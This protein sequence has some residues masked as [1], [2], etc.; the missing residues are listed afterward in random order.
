MFVWWLTFTSAT[1]A[2]CRRNFRELLNDLQTRLS[3]LQLTVLSA[4]LYQSN[5]ISLLFTNPI[6]HSHC[7]YE[8][9]IITLIL[10]NNNKQYILYFSFRSSNNDRLFLQILRMWN[11][12]VARQK[13]AC[14]DLWI[15]KIEA[16]L[17]LLPLSTHQEPGPI[18]L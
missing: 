2:E 1:T 14:R 17:T 13:T 3:T 7:R 4:V 10:I 9:F 18:K 11:F 6:A 12:I 5:I 15:L 8:W 16:V